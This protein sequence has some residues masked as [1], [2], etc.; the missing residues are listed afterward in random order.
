VALSESY[1]WRNWSGYLAA[2]LYDPLHDREYYAMRSAAALIDVSPL[3]KYEL[4]GP[5]AL[6]LANR[7]FTRDF[8]RCAV[9]Q[10]FYTPWCDDDGQVIDDGTVTRLAADVLCVTSAEA[11]LA[12]FEDC[13]FGMDVRVRDISAEL[14][15]LALQGPLA[16]AILAALAPDNDLAA[17]KYYRCMEA[18]LGGIPVR[19]SR[20]GYTGD[21]GYELWA[22]ANLALS[23]WDRLMEAGEGYGLVPAG[24][25]A[26]DIAR[27]EAGLMMGGVDYISARK[28]LIDEQTS[29]PAELGLGW[30][31]D[32]SKPAFVG[33]K[34]LLAEARRGA[35]WKFVG[36]ELLWDDLE[37]VFGRWKL[38]PQV[39]GRASRASVPVYLE[40]RQIGEMTSHTFSPLLKRYIGLAS[41]HGDAPTEGGNVDV[42]VT[43]EYT[44]LKARARVCKLPFYNPARKRN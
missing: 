13:A 23:L 12:W 7:I 6:R 30:A 17:L 37:A 14:A 43:V 40:G 4:R 3:Y 25:V 26:L 15:A 11:N 35:A 32:F 18:H 27:I 21:L 22:P 24:M 39:A 38:T 1:E 9:G 33:R 42:E 8:S 20:T 31:V 2:A 44:R 29:T 10:V 5:E 41:L 34:A 36:L 19:V 16:R 28:A